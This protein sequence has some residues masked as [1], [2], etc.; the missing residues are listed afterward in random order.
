MGWLA[1][2]MGREDTAPARKMTSAELGQIIRRG[3]QAGSGAT[4]NW[5]TALEQATVLACVRVIADG[6]AQVPWKLYRAGAGRIEAPDHPLYDLIASAPNPL[7]SSFSFRETMVLH[8]ALTGNAYVWMMRV[9][10][11]RRIAS[12]EICEPQRMRVTRELDGVLRYFYTPEGS[13]EREIPR[14]DMWHLRGPSWNA[15]TGMDAVKLAREAI[16]LSIATEAAHADMHR[17]GVRTSGFIAF[18]DVLTKDQYDDLREQ[19]KEFAQGGEN[20]GMPFV[21]DHD[22]KY[23]TTQMSGVDAQHLETRR[24]QVEEICRGF[25]VM[26]IMAGVPGAAGA[27]DN[28]EQMFI[29]H[30]VHTLMPWYARIEQSADMNLLT[31]Q[32]RRDGYYTKFNPNG[33]MR[34]AAKDRAE[35]YAKALG[36]GGTPAWMKQDEVRG[37]EEL[38]P[39]GGAADQLNPGSMG[40]KPPA[41]TGAGA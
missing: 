34:G 25:R 4:V 32:E 2:I 5:V 22:A 12:L 3:H 30:V 9:G 6:V 40:Q 23:Q 39:E 11:D 17:N 8:A 20:A 26:P 10:I 36:A 37:L 24:Y 33:L 18:K 16:G 38:A 15:A 27:Y 21:F 13:T 14:Q 31:E 7:Q 19:L 35:Y 1:R 29:A 28:G 41:N